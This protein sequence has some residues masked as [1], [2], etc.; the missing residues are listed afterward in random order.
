[1][2]GEGGNWGVKT[3]NIYNACGVVA[4]KWKWSMVRT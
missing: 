2:E 4:Y 3:K 1:M